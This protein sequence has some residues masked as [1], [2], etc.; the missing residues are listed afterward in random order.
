MSPDRLP[1]IGP[2]SASDG[3]WAL[4]GFG[5]RGLVWASLCAELLASQIAADPLPIEAELVQAVGVSRF[6]DKRRSR[7]RM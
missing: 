1:I 4:N 2:L 6:G 5:A 3:L 7:G